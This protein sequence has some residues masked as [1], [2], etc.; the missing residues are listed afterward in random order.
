MN[1]E[2]PLRTFAA[3]HTHKPLAEKK[4]KNNSKTKTIRCNCQAEPSAQIYNI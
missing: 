3:C 4:E 2:G 1:E